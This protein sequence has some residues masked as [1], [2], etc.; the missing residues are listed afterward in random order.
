[1]NSVFSLNFENIV[2]QILKED[3]SSKS[4]NKFTPDYFW[5]YEKYYELNK[6]LFGN[7]LGSCDFEVKKLGARTLGTFSF[8]A[9]IK[10]E[11]STRRL[12]KSDNWGYKEYIN[13]DNFVDETEPLISLNSNYKGTEHAWLGTLAHEMCHYYT[14][15]WGYAPLQAHGREFREIGSEIAARSNGEFTIARLASAEEM[16]EYELDDKVQASQKRRKENRINKMT[17]IFILDSTNV[18]RLVMTTSQ[19]LI[20]EIEKIGLEQT[21][22]YMGLNADPNF[23]KKLMSL[24][25][26]HNM[27]TYRWW[28]LTNKLALAII[29]L[30]KWETLINNTDKTLAQLLG[31]EEPSKPQE[32]QPQQQNKPQEEFHLGYKIV[33]DGEGFNLETQDGRRTF[34]NP[35]KSIFFDENNNQ[36]QFSTGKFT[37]KG[38]PGHWTKLT[39]ESVIKEKIMDDEQDDDA[40]EITP[41]MNLGLMSPFEWNDLTKQ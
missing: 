5:M 30:Q 39:T 4:Q 28:N 37:F 41:N 17:A 20:N 27:R 14:Y 22:N 13:R 38:T 26:N 21:Y 15:L 33:K 9:N 32:E 3:A 24:G 6:R 12:Y 8:K 18:P 40:V 25:Y 23:V 36:F 16:R 19:N 1:M 35:V 2:A 10:I 11:R 34:K 31:V 29:P 7:R